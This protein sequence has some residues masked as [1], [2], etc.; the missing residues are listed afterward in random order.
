M[1]ND[2]AGR[3]TDYTP[4]IGDEILSLMAEGF[5]LA[6]AAA[7]LGIHR[8]R[9]YDWE[10]KHPDFADTIKL[11]RA[12]RQL[13]LERR[14]LS[15]KEGPVV[16]SSIF[17]LKNAAPDDWRDKREHEVSGPGG[18]PMEQVTRIE[19]VAAETDDNG[20]D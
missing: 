19:I 11:A 13:F 15:A 20:K 2:M 9:V 6:A 17:A 16:T 4:A 18:G 7:E 10:A 8:Q 14:L 12:K 3:P 5:S 1:G